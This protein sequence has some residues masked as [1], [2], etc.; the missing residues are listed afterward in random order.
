MNQVDGRNL[1]EVQRII[2]QTVNKEIWASKVSPKMQLFIWKIIHGV[3]PLGENLAKRGMLNNISCRHCDE[4]ETADH[5]FLHCNFTRQ[6]WA[7]NMW[8]QD[9]NPSDCSSFTTA[10]LAS[11]RL[12]TLS[13]L[14]VTETLIFSPAEILSKAIF[15]AREWIVAQPRA[16][17]SHSAQT[18]SALRPPQATTETT[19]YTDAAWSQATNRAG[20]GW[21]FMNHENV[22]F[23]Q[24]ARAFQFISS[25]LMAEAIAIRSALLHALEAGI[26][27]ICIKSDCQ[28]LIVALS[29]KRH[30]RIS[31]ESLGTSRHYP[32][33][34]LAFH[35]VS[36]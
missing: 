16:Q 34:S 2:E 21:C 15:C 4:L 10:L 13:P 36:F 30:R 26:L 23:L 12:T 14:G 7:A 18:A 9:F 17:P 32:Y 6:V 19:C 25:P 3:T 5:L 33:V 31:T 20:C 29:S 35:F 22:V 11:S 27:E 24:D 1:T 28:A 8:K